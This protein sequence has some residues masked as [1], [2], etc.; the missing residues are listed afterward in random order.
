MIVIVGFGTKLRVGLAHESAR[1]SVTHAAFAAGIHR[2]AARTEHD[3][4]MRGAELALTPLGARMLL[5]VP[6]HH[7][8]SC[9]VELEDLLGR[10]AERLAE[11]LY[12]AR[13]WAA[14]FD[15]LDAVLAARLADAAEPP[16]EVAWAWRDLHAAG[17]RMAIGRLTDELG[18][19]RK[20][21]A[22]AFREHVGLSPKGFARVLRFRRAV[23]LVRSGQ[24]GWGEIALAAGYYDQ[25]HF[26][27]D[28]R[29]FAGV[30]PT[31]FA[32]RLS[33]DDPGVAGD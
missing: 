16:P 27:R 17:G 14:R 11:R 24:A 32:R 8:S 25:A 20:R 10:D 6:M 1:A 2:A 13:T 31:E 3:G 33:P 22:A 19:S 12:E 9:T 23:E 28:F 30:T 18:W 21:L 26:N 4:A 15:L 29:E 7:L 5:G